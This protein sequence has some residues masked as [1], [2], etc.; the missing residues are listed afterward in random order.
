[1][2]SASPHQLNTSDFPNKER[3][4]RV[5]LFFTTS[6]GRSR[7]RHPAARPFFCPYR[8]PEIFP[9]TTPESSRT[10]SARRSVLTGT[11]SRAAALARF[12]RA[13][14]PSLSATAS[15]F[16][17]ASSAADDATSATS[18]PPC[19]TSQCHSA[20]IRNTERSREP[21]AARSTVKP[22]GSHCVNQQVFMPS[23][24]AAACRHG[25][26]TGRRYRPAIFRHRASRPLPGADIPTA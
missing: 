6:G 10:F 26:R 8:G 3:R 23:A 13:P 15:A 1:M 20:S 4:L 16:R 17:R 19:R 5:S 21:S 7:F 9:E 2:V 14:Q 18:R 12:F 11:R 25:R 24:P 22:P